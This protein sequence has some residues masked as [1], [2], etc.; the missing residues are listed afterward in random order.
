MRIKSQNTSFLTGNIS[1][2]TEYGENLI[3]MVAGSDGCGNYAVSWDAGEKW[4]AGQFV[5]CEDD[6][7]LYECHNDGDEFSCED[8]SILIARRRQDGGFVWETGE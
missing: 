5:D 7:E 2:K 4:M 1:V 3:L 8:G 6:S